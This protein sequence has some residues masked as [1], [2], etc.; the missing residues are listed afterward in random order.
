MAGFKQTQIDD[1][2]VS[3]WTFD[4][5]AFDS[6][7]RKLIV[8]PGEP[9]Y[10]ID[11]ID[12][13]NPAILHNDN[14]TYPGY[15][16][17]MPSLVD[18]EQTDQQSMSFA[19]A[20]RQPA[21][22]N[23]WA[24]T[25]L[26]VPH[27][28]SYAFPR[29][30]AFSVEFLF[31]K[32]SSWDEGTSAYSSYTRPIISK[33]GVFDIYFSFPYSDRSRIIASTPAGNVTAYHDITTAY[34]LIGTVN[35]Y[36]LVWEN[37]LVDN[38]QYRG[39]ASVY[40]NGYLVGTASQTYFDV[41][42][43]TNLNNPIL[44]AGRTGSNRQ[45]DYHTSDFRLD[46][47]AIYDR[48]L[49]SD[50]VSN[51]FS[52]IFPYDKMIAH[53]FA[54]SF[55]T[56]ADTDSTIDF[57]VYP[58]VG[59]LQGT[60]LGVRNFNFHRGVDGPDNLMG[61]KAASFGDGGMASFISVNQYN[62]YLARQI[63]SAY[64]YEAWFAVSS[65]RRAVLLAAQ[66]LAWPFDGPL[67]QINMRDN[68]EFIGCLQFTEGDN[69][70]V[71]NS[72]YL[73]DNNSRF[74]FN[75]GNWHHI[76]I[77]RRSN[78]MMELW[79]DGILHDSSIEATRSVGQPGQLVVMNSLPGQLNCNGSICKLAY[80]GYALQAQ[81]IKNHYTYTVTYRIRGI[82]TLL[83]VPYQATL[84]FYNSYTGAFIQELI[85]DPN[86][87]EYEAIFYNNANIDILVFSASDLSVRYRAYGPVT[88]S[89]FIDLPVNL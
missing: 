64:S 79:L 36:V 67:I 27:T 87:G 34:N 65:L 42:P 31:F 60:Y 61:S 62:T 76:V 38:G 53:E 45:S 32:A 85:S 69:G 19:F 26:E 70:A 57:T 52:K 18:F 16:L 15:R 20:G 82:V 9:N 8:P 81:Q 40:V 28:L 12:N 55:W 2:A 66:E 56:F 58:A 43:N 3:L 37:L 77:L 39:T 22:P 51:H 33:S 25:Y 88:P 13:L 1:D 46:Q 23:Q 54:S 17:G 48:A 44:I 21:H 80:Y 49:S 72:R 11:E 29:Y 14:E 41:F 30:G 83:G 73:N 7:S 71:L 84:R 68:Q 24:K 50:E 78:G 59:G 35:H 4:G 75:D 63:N 47:I 74:L 86:T 5:D 6:G 89:E 10:I